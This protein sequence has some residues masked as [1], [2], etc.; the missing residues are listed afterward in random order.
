M[1]TTQVGHVRV[2]T[3][4]E[5]LG[6]GDTV[7]SSATA[8]EHALVGVVKDDNLNEAVSVGLRAVGEVG[9]R[10]NVGAFAALTGGGRP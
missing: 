6:R 10:A 4:I 1:T 7:L 3:T 2:T 9:E 8:T 5:L